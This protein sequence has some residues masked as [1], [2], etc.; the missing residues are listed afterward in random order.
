MLKTTKKLPDFF[1]IKSQSE[2]NS[3]NKVIETL[4]LLYLFNI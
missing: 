3:Q 1:L 2:Y 4:S